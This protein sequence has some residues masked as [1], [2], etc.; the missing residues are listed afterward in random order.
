MERLAGMS[1]GLGAFAVCGGESLDLS[2]VVSGVSGGIA[3]ARSVMELD[4]RP[5]DAE[6]RRLLAATVRASFEEAV[7]DAD[8][9][10]GE[11]EEGEGW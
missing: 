2:P 10:D 6:L 8:G 9:C 5:G 1:D 11:G 7:A 4:G 3:L